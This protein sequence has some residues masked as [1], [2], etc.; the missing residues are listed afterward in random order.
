[1]AGQLNFGVGCCFRRSI[2]TEKEASACGYCVVGII[3]AWTYSREWRH[4][5][6]ML[7]LYFISICS[8]FSMS[9]FLNSICC[10][11][12][13]CSQIAFIPDLSFYLARLNKLKAKLC[14]FSGYFVGTHQLYHTP[15]E[16]S[17]F[18]FD[19]H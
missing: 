17:Y 7:L 3:I 8:C 4:L 5:C 10:C 18:A 13:F 14:C 2:E 11:P 9:S 15:S 12:L 19:V 6:W 16:Q 1:M